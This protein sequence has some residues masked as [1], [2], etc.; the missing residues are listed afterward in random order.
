M[1]KLGDKIRTIGGDLYLGKRIPALS[2]G[3]IRGLPTATINGLYTVEIDGATYFLAP[4]EIRKEE[5][6]G[7]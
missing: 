3:V 5:I 6:D 7:T 2:S 1:L 4:R